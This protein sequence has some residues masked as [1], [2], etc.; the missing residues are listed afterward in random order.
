MAETTP[1]KSSG[2]D[3]KLASLLAW[4]FA[5]ITSVIFMVMD[6][7]KRD[8]FIQFNAKESLYFFVAEIIIYIIFG[9]LAT[10]SFGILSCLLPILS[11]ADLGIRIYVGVQAYNGK[12]TVLPVIG[13]MAEKK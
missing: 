2:M 13:P 6:D 1:T 12:K 11:L 8:E 3:P 9:V 5:P 10:I 4:I 7:M